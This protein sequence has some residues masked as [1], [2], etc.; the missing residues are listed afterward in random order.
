[1]KKIFIKLVNRVLSFNLIQSAFLCLSVCVWVYLMTTPEDIVRLSSDL[2]ITY[3]DWFWSK[4]KLK[5][6]PK[7]EK[8]KKV[9]I[10]SSISKWWGFIAHLSPNIQVLKKSVMATEFH[11]T[12]SLIV[13]LLLINNNKLNSIEF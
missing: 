2:F 10:L 8:G 9:L 6:L 4:S 7:V 11:R 13:Y 1:M 5:F 12:V 3:P